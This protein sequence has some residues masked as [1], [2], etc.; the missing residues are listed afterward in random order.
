MELQGTRLWE[1]QASRRP[2]RGRRRPDPSPGPRE[3]G[4]MPSCLLVLSLQVWGCTAA[5]TCLGLLLLA[6]ELSCGCCIFW[7]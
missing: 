5:A 6:L 1:V 4:L 2:L 3:W 7:C